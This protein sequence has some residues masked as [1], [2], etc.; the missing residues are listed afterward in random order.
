MELYCVQLTETI[1]GRKKISS[2]IFSN[3]IHLPTPK[4]RY[5][6]GQSGSIIKTTEAEENWKFIRNGRGFI[7]GEKRENIFV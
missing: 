4:V 5:A 2:K 6:V 3:T 7:V 1:L